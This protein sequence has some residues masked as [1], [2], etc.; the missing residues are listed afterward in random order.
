[1]ANS[2]FRSRRNDRSARRLVELRRRF[3]VE[4][5]E[6]REMLSTFT[7]TSTAD[8]TATGTL[9]WAITQSDNTTG[10]STVDFEIAGTGVQTINLT[11]ALPA[12]TRPV[13]IDGT[14]QM[15]YSS[16]PVLAP[17]IV[18]NGSGAGTSAVGLSLTSSATGTTVKGL[19][20]EDFAGG[21]VVI[22]GGS[23]DTITDELIGLTAAGTV[24]APNGGNG[25]TIEGNATKN[26]IS[27]DVISGNIGSGIRIT[28]TGTTGNVVTGNL[29]GTDVHGAHAVPNNG[30]A[31]VD[32][33]GGASHNT[34]GGT[35][36]AAQ[37]HFGQ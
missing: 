4:P 10:P 31:G 16:S 15:G 32:I 13:T 5:L 8:T 6:G 36:V 29:I 2:G 17:V 20:I 25:V 3:L 35:T 7:V 30:G 18:L 27:A 11:S 19:V 26:T 28:G 24:A 34:V 1:M 23:M 9:R 33:D 14:S 21:G 22:N 12:I 37:H